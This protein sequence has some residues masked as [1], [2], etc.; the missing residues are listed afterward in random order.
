MDDSASNTTP[1]VL[2]SSAVNAEALTQVESLIK[3]HI[4]LLDTS[5]QELKN[6]R[7]MLQGIF[8]NDPTYQEHERLAK[9]ASKVKNA[10]KQR[11]SQAPQAAT[12]VDKV[13]DLRAQIGEHRDSLSALL[14]DFARLSGGGNEIETD[15]G[16]IREIVYLAKLIKK[17]GLRQ[18]K[19]G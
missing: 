4:S 8:D 3:S 18:S 9:E 6:V 2:D 11:L 12:L 1:E 16:E 15:D 14:Q 17:S 5:T 7:E 19:H 13:K 10:T